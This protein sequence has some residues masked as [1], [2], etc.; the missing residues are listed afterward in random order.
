M[1]AAMLHIT[2]V[3][4]VVLLASIPVSAADP[5]PLV[6]F[7][8]PWTSPYRIDPAYP[9]HLVNAEGHH[10]F[11]LNKTAWAFFGCKNPGAYLD[12]AKTE[13]ITVIRVALEGRPYWRDLHIEQWPW[14]GSRERPDFTSFSQSYWDE[15]ERRIRLAGD[16][17]IGIDLC[18][19]FT[20]HP[21]D[22]DIDR[23]RAYWQHTLDRLARYANILTWEIHNEHL[24]N[25]AF[26]DAAGKFFRDND[27]FHRPVCTSDGTTDDAAWP[28]KPWVSMAINH[29]CTSST[30][31]HPLDA[32]YLA[33]ARNTRS[34]G[35][36]AWCN[37]SGREK[38]HGND[39]GVHR[40]KQAWLWNC[41]GAY[42]THHS[43]NGCEGIDDAAYRAPGSEYLPFLSR[44]FQSIPFWKLNPNYT[45]FR[46]ADRDVIWTGLTDQDRG[47]TIAYV[48]V[49][50][51]GRRVENVSGSL[52]LPNGR[53]RVQFIAPR[54]GK[55][56][57]A[58]DHVSKGLR[59]VVIQLPAFEDDL[60][61]KITRV[62]RQDRT[63]L[64]GTE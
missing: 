44:F 43:W 16:K 46:V 47:L 1:I 41:A 33:V 36:P 51:S 50:K 34:H 62:Q 13:G 58:R 28:D 2:R 4:V 26:Q 15:V 39:D 30:G 25:E 3:T 24:G 18:I 32:W 11:I 45:A 31:R 6:S 48:C 61:V 19:Y 20:L 54:D 29:T 14:G 8:A 7:P 27:P 9:H 57:E 12:K 56:V 55:E 5:P 21:A 53:Y 42:W 63:A 17:G 60:V 23:H 38:R 22:S 40:R 35:K 10:L 64:P 49:E 37:E 52:R 59:E